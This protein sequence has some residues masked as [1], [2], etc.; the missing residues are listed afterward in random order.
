MFVWPMVLATVLVSQHSSSVTVHVDSARHEITVTA[1][2]F[3]LPPNHAHSMAHPGTTMPGKAHDIPAGYFAWPVDG[4]FRGFRLRAVDGQGR[5]L[6]RGIIHHLILVNF[7]RRQLVYA[8]AERLMGA[9][10]ETDDAAVPKTVG[11]P[12][13]PG[14][15]L[16]MYLEWH[17]ATGQTLGDVHLELTLLWIPQNQ[18]PRPVSAFPVYMDANLTVGGSNTFDIPPGRS[19]KA[20]E[21]ALP[22]GGR[23]LAVGGHLHDLGVR[24]QLD[25]AS[26][27]KVLTEVS[28]TRNAEGTVTG[29]GRRLFGVRGDGLKLERG[30]RYRIVGVYDNPTRET[31]VNGAMAHMVGLFV[32]EDVAKWPRIDPADGDY[33]HDLQSL[34]VS[35]DSRGRVH[36]TPDSAAHHP[37]SMHHGV[38]R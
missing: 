8:A 7:G 33:R 18:V 11:V 1:G 10:A 34:Q 15:P 32:P 14:M 3:D 31:R 17:N 27:G 24:V 2:P 16:G 12:M 20:F 23:L 19:S 6:S 28:A 4:W 5:P 30:R 21:F 26:T 37:A 13:S 35:V 22:V 29:V 25:D 36:P 38:S 9:G